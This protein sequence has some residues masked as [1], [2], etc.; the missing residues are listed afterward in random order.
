MID[1]VND[2]IRIYSSGAYPPNSSLARWDISPYTEPLA[3]LWQPTPIETF[4]PADDDTLLRV[5]KPCPEADE[6]KE[7]LLDSRRNRRLLQRH[8][9]MLDQ[10]EKILSSHLHTIEQVSNVHENMN[11]MHENAYYWY[12]WQPESGNRSEE[13]SQWT[14]ES[15]EEIKRQ[16]RQFEMAKYR[17]MFDDDFIKQ[18][19]AGELLH[20]IGDIFKSRRSVLEPATDLDRDYRLNL[21]STHDTKLVALLQTLNVWNHELVPYLGTLM[22]ELHQ[23]RENSSQYYV[24]LWYLNETADLLESNYELRPH[25]LDIP[26]CD[27]DEFDADDLMCPLDDF[28]ILIE[29]FRPPQDWKHSCGVHSELTAMISVNILLLIVNLTMMFFL[30]MGIMYVCSCINNRSGYERLR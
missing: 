20:R 27:H 4:I 21:Y 19:R 18:V 26:G 10:L 2:H 9:Q 25:R 28:L 14:Q 8:R 23:S 30:L 11:I 6:T 17:S 22:F 5:N 7:R 24:Q 13:L 1:S 3:K 16:L 12:K 15:E 29:P